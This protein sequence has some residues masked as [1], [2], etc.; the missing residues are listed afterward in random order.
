MSCQVV[1][2]S[3]INPNKQEKEKINLWEMLKKHMRGNFLSHNYAQLMYQRLQNLR[4]STRC[5]DDYTKE[6]DQLVLQNDVSDTHE[7]MVSG[8]I[9]GLCDV[10][11]MDACHLFYQAVRSECQT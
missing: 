1:A 4:Q 8:D 7:Q 11:T 3:Q 10:M 2:T 6:F 9:G 5:V